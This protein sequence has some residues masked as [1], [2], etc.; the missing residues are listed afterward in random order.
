MEGQ[1]LTTLFPQFLYQIEGIQSPSLNI[2][3]D[4]C[5]VFLQISFTSKGATKRQS[6]YIFRVALKRLCMAQKREPSFGKHLD[7]SRCAKMLVRG[8]FVLI[9]W[10]LFYFKAALF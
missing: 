7:F 5:S 8:F 3:N 6:I 9:L 1:D 10:I 2:M 4:I